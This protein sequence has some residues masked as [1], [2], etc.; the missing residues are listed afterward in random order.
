[1]FDY[2]YQGFKINLN[3]DNM[4]LHC[5]LLATIRNSSHGGF[6]YLMPYF[7]STSYIIWQ[8]YDKG[9]QVLTATTLGI[10]AYTTII[11]Y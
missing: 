4:H 6:V 8:A 1:M 7:W 5:A 11:G 2:D 3:I 9:N 10:A